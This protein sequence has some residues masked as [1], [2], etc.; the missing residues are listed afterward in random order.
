MGT[1]YNPGPPL[2]PEEEFCE[3]QPPS[4]LDY[5]K[6]A[7][8]ALLTILAGGVVWLGVALVIHR[9]SGFTTVI[10]GF[11]AGWAIHW[12]AAR[13]RSVALGIIAG[14]ATVLAG[15][16][17]YVLTWLPLVRPITGSRPLSWFDL[18]IAGL[19]AFAAYRIASPKSG[20]KIL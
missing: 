12:A 10:V 16:A 19:G 14:A 17:G 18:I 6:A 15:L 9:P 4:G 8:M 2:T 11:G 7:G 1:P 3:C 5:V 20:M 13:R